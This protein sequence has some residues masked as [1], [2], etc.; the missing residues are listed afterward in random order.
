MQV[1]GLTNIT[2]IEA[3]YCSSTAIKN[4]GTIWRWGSDF[5]VGLGDGNVV[6]HNT[7]F[8]L[9]TIHKVAS[10]ASGY[11]YSIAI[12]NDGTIWSWGD[13]GYGQVGDGTTTNRLFPV[14]VAF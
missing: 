10:Y 12:K 1:I 11:N 6:G 14:Q 13:N 4:D 2:A 7:P 5:A 9:P 8:L 3:G